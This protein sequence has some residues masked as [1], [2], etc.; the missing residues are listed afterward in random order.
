MELASYNSL[1]YLLEYLCFLN[2]LCKKLVGYGL[3]FLLLKWVR[4]ETMG[5]PYVR[6]RRL[7]SL[8]CADIR[9]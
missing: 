6:R 1:C 9:Q 3:Q 5:P 7:C 2:A 4:P 8:F